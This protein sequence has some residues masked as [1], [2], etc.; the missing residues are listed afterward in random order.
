M[1]AYF[2]DCSNNRNFK[3]NQMKPINLKIN[4]SKEFRK[5]E[6]MKKCIYCGKELEEDTIIEVCHECGAGVWGEKM[7]QAIIDNMSK[8]KEKGDLNQGCVFEN[9]ESERADRFI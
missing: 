2:R 8:A 4:K 6:K 1:L 3:K 9:S 5:E 7:F